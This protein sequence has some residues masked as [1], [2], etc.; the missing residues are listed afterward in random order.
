LA[1]RRTTRANVAPIR[2]RRAAVAV[3]AML[4]EYPDPE[5]IEVTKA[6]FP[7]KGV[8]NAEEARVRSDKPL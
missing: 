5:F 8:A 2:S 6:N 4:A 3:R 1:G 7:E